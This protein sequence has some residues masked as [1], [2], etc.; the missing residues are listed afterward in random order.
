[1]RN[2]EVIQNIQEDTH[3]LY[4]NHSV[5]YIQSGMSVTFFVSLGGCPVD[6]N[7]KNPVGLDDSQ[8]TR[9]LRE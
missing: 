5:F 6:T 1:M 2:L 9:N 3:G 7:S 4:T 8:N